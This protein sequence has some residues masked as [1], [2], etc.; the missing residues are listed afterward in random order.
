MLEQL[1]KPDFGKKFER[2][3]DQRL[4]FEF[5]N[6]VVK[7]FDEKDLDKD[8]VASAVKNVLS[9]IKKDDSDFAELIIET[10]RTDFKDLNTKYNIV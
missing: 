5:A 2:I 4:A 10:I 8:S 1:K 9:D 3:Q 7:L 6:N